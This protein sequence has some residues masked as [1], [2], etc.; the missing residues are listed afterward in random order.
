LMKP[1]LKS[2]SAI[3]AWLCKST[4]TGWYLPDSAIKSKQLRRQNVAEIVFRGG[5]WNKMYYI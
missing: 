1:S 2:S 5:K 4:K 3:Y